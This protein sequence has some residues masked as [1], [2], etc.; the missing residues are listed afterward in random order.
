MIN[1]VY[2]YIPMVCKYKC[3]MNELPVQIEIKS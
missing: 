2:N 3:N 1:F